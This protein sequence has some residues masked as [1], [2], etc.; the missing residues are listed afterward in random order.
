MSNDIQQSKREAGMSPWKIALVFAVLCAPSARA[1]EPTKPEQAPPKPVEPEKEPLTLPPLPGAE[2]DAGLKK[3]LLELFAKVENRL[4]AIDTQMYD[5]ATGRVPTKPISG[6]GI[7]DLLRAGQ[8]MKKPENVGELL[9]S[10]A[11][12]SQQ[13]QT[14]IQRMLQIAEQMNKNSKQGGGQGKPKP[15]PGGES[16]LDKP[17]NGQPAPREATPKA[18]GPK[19]DGKQPGEGQ[20]PKDSNADPKR[21]GANQLGQKPPD[22]K[23]GPGS[24]ASGADRWGDLPVRAREIF[25]VE[26][27]SDLPPQYRDW[28]DGYY[29]R[30]QNLERH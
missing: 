11:R 17:G 22:Q 9:Q 21:P 24:Q 26:G 29:R 7:E 3:E 15:S 2:P 28:I 8:P 10:A 23:T 13:T 18:P 25:R 4:H 30:L 1:Q 14:D 12:D 5:A 27:A 20:V 19:P 16:P 6:S